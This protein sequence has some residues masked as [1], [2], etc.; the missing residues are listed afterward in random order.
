MPVTGAGPEPIDMGLVGD[1]ASIDVELFEQLASAG[2][3]LAL[4][5]LCGDAKTRGRSPDALRMVASQLA[6][7]A[8]REL[9]RLGG[10]APAGE[11]FDR[12]FEA[13]LPK[14]PL[15]A[16]RKTAVE[17]AWGPVREA[18]A[19]VDRFALARTEPFRQPGQLLALALEPDACTGCGVCIERC[20][21]VAL[22]PGADDAD[23]VAAARGVTELVRT[24]P[25]PTHAALDA[26]ASHP[27]AGPLPAA[28]L[29]DE[30]RSIVVGGDGAEPGSGARTAARQVLGTL[31]HHRARAVGTV[32]GEIAELREG[33]AAAI[34]EGLARSLPG[35]DLDAL[36]RGLETLSRPDAELSELTARVEG[37]FESERV[38]ASR[39]RR[40]V[41]S[42]RRL[43]DL[44]WR[45]GTGAG[46]R[47][48][49]PFGLVVAP[50]ADSAWAGSFPANPFA[51]PVVLDATGDAPAVAVGIARGLAEETVETARALRLAR[52]ELERPA[53]AG[54]VEDELRDLGWSDLEPDE[55]SACPP[56]VLL[57]PEEALAGPSGACLAELLRLLG[58]DLP[59]IAL[60]LA[61]G[62][63]GLGV[64]VSTGRGRAARPLPVEPSLLALAEPRAFVLQSSIAFPDHLAAGLAALSEHDGPSL[65][66]LHAPSPRRHGFPADLAVRRAEAAVLSRVVPLF[67][68]TPADAPGGPAT[69]VLDGNPDPEELWHAD[70]D[71]IRFARGE[72]RFA[73]RFHPA[74]NGDPDAEPDSQPNSQP[75]AGPALVAAAVRVAARWRTL[76]G[77]ALADRELIAAAV[78]EAEERTARSL[79][80]EH[81]RERTALTAAYE[82]RIAGIEDETRRRMAFTVRDRLVTL[83]ALASEAPR[84]EAG[85]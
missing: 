49:A 29:S 1:V 4:G 47:G 51:V 36:A 71:P 56:T 64:D 19:S 37:A 18:L 76:Q 28:L 55:R 84:E 83:A 6:D 22:A 46:G 66:R 60:C 58:D 57:V 59:V 69:V 50:G 45:L 70:W 43:S 12:A 61:E 72:A 7:A 33:L 30:A 23:A 16:E 8:D 85:S 62:D 15:P 39:L 26:A 17:E 31:A 5:S 63:L 9:D 32:R 73:G 25:P 40:L 65:V 68:A 81:E 10:G 2:I 75:G 38:D 27:E 41:A 14:L 79:A 3:V 52:A 24:L 13:V 74:A 53:E 77:M 21:P 44:D 35:T 34:H 80:A 11:L 82:S 20:E 42:A 67:R 48:T 78:A 54:R